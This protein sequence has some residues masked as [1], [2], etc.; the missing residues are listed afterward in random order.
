MTKV[1]DNNEKQ[2]KTKKSKNERKK[3]TLPDVIVNET[4][5]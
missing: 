4:I 2:N 3:Y 1:S 5:Q